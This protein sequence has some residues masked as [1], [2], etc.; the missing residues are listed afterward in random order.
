MWATSEFQRFRSGGTK[1]GHTGRRSIACAKVLP[2]LRFEEEFLPPVAK[3]NFKRLLSR[4]YP[5]I[6]TLRTTAALLILCTA[7][8]ELASRSTRV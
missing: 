4:M 7:V 1:A 2:P 5:L 6:R 8:T 3:S